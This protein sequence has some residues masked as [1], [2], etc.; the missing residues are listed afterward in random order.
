[1]L[2]GGGISSQVG[3][4]RRLKDSPKAGMGRSVLWVHVPPPAGMTAWA[5]SG[6]LVPRG[7]GA[8]TG[9]SLRRD[10]VL[11]VCVEAR[12]L[13]TLMGPLRLT[14]GMPRWRD[15]GDLPSND[16]KFLMRGNLDLED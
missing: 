10:P 15:P 11:H 13:L 5:S 8:D 16:R 6:C 2:C 3:G 4:V 7:A 1:M 14:S 12:D 9:L